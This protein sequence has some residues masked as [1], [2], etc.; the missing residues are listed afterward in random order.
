LA[1]LS[2]AVD[3]HHPVAVAVEGD[4][5]ICAGLSNACDQCLGMGRTDA[6]VDVHTIGI[7]A[8]GLDPCA[9]LAQ[10][11]RADLV[12]RAVG[13]VDDDAHAAEVEAARHRALA[14]FHVAADGVAGAHGLAEL[15]GRHGAERL[16]ERGLDRQLGG[17]VE[18]LAFGREELDAVVV[19]R[20][21]RGTDDDAAVGAER[22]REVRH[23]RRRHRPHQ[24]H[25]HARSDQAGLQ[26]GLEHV[27]RDARVLADHHLRLAPLPARPRIRAHAGLA[28]GM[29]VGVAQPQ[30]EIRRDRALAHAPADAVGAEV[31]SC[32]RVSEL[33]G[34]CGGA[35]P[36][37]RVTSS[38]A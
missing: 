18:F 12:G 16:V 15:V 11:Q 34:S 8:D 7:D 31:F 13:A 22:A 3:E 29:A 36:T 19:V 26:R 10:H 20:V 24:L 9:H 35:M 30:H 25:V 17:V 5:E 37:G 23:R 32:H 38:R 1:C 28:Q 2:V 33:L 6:V 4:A 27:V 21:V 14:G